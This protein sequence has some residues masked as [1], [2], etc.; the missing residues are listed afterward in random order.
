MGIAPNRI[1]KAL[2]KNHVEAKMLVRD[3][4]SED[5]NVISINTSWIAKKINFLRFVWERF[6]ILLCNRFNYSDLY[7]VSIANTGT[8]IISHPLVE[9]A[10]IIHLHWTNQGFLS[11]K[12]IHAL[13]KTGKPIVWTMHDMWTCTGICHHAWGCE[14]FMKE[15]GCCPLIHSHK[16]KDL[17]YRIFKTKHFISQ[18]NIHIVTVSSWL[19]HMAQKSAIT[20]NLMSSVIPNVIDLQNFQASDRASARKKLNLPA[21]K[22][23]ISMGAYNIDD[24]IKGFIFLKQAMQKIYP[25][26][27]D[28]LLVL[29]GNIKKKH[30]LKDTS[31]PVIHLGH[32][33]DVSCIAQLYAAADVN[34]VPS[35]YETFGQTITEA[36]ACGCPS[37][38][39][40]NSGQTDIID[41]K[42]NGYLAEYKNSEDLAKG[43][44]WV[45]SKD[46][47]GLADA[48]IKKVRNNYS[49]AI[50]AEQYINL[51]KNLLN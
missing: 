30:I 3:K 10:D 24:P 49:E 31:F 20:G 16:Q 15:C 17:S 43:I 25:E 26:N 32:I 2:R 42:I 21:D 51:Y 14:N 35:Y 18:S 27:K 7:K 5:V 19:K 28:I 40:N 23:I 45:L 33:N 41:H 38:S 36:M 50:V 34:V 44:S 6:I 13:V 1:Y 37:V 47:K 8:D 39:F 48:C 46:R 9:E 22:K 12:N 4:I 11:I 29:F